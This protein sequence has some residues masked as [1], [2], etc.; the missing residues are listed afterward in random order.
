MPDLILDVCILVG[1]A[2]AVCLS[3]LISQAIG[4]G[5][6]RILARAEESEA[7]EKGT[8][9]LGKENATWG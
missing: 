1:V 7:D 5:V 2:C 9:G 8:P 3:F 4:H 6:T